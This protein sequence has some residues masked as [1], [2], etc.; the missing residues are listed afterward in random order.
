M[1]ELRV[2]VLLAGPARA[3]DARTI[4]D[5]LARVAPYCGVQTHAFES[6]QQLNDESPQFAR[7]VAAALWAD[8]VLYLPPARDTRSNA[9]LI[10]LR[11]R[12]GFTKRY[13]E[14]EFARMWMTPNG[15]RSLYVIGEFPGAYGALEHALEFGCADPDG[16]RRLRTIARDVPALSV[17]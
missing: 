6:A 14:P 1:S 15:R 8:V 3:D 9:A 12:S 7:G 17:A 2:S 10:A 4:R 16:A 5:L 13:H 11:E